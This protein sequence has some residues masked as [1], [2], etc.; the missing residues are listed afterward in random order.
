METTAFQRTVLKA[1]RDSKSRIPV[2]DR[3]RVAIWLAL[4]GVAREMEAA[5]SMELALGGNEA[6]AQGI[7][8]WENFDPE[9]F[10]VLIEA[11]IKIISMFL[12]I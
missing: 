6:A 11:I 9:K 7:I 5:V 1:V 4:P 2:R 3:V 8:D 10:M 12:T